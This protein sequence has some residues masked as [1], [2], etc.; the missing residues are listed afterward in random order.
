M[1]HASPPTEVLEVCKQASKS[2]S[3]TKRKDAKGPNWEDP[4]WLLL[5]KA[6]RFGEENPIGISCKEG[7]LTVAR[8]TKA[9]KNQRMVDH[10]NSLNPRS[11]NCSPKL[12]ASYW[13]KME[14]SYL[15]TYF[16]MSL[17]LGT[18][19]VSV[20]DVIMIQRIE[21]EL[22]ASFSTRSKTIFESKGM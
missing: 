19:L 14:V 21:E 10:F 9:A 12:F 18:S 20:L 1:S 22:V 11:G 15:Y 16:H 17:M 7:A 6:V 4:E 5:I 8:E 13:A 2:N 3:D